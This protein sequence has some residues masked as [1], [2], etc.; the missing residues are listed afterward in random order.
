MQTRKKIIM[1]TGTSLSRL[2]PPNDHP[3]PCRSDT[4]EFGAYPSAVPSARM[5][6][7]AVLAEW[8]L[9]GLSGDAEVV[10]TELME[11]AIQATRK[12]GLDTPVC[13]TLVAG[14]DTVLV[15]V[16]DAV[17]APPVPRQA[18]GDLD[19]LGL[20]AADSDDDD[21]DQHGRG[22]LIVSALSAWWDWKRTLG[23]GKVVRALVKV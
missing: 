20:L 15:T 21:P 2:P 8:K 17:D 1:G 23:R 19:A 9:D 3:H 22:L 6:V 16:R 13:L 14:T 4:L 18:T 11:N 12:A 10:A 5:H 7:R